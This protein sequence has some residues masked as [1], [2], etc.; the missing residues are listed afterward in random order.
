MLGRGWAYRVR[1]WPNGRQAISEF[2]LP[3]DIIGVHAALRMHHPAR[4][5]ALQPVMFQA[6]N[7]D[8]VPTLLA[9]RPVATYLLWL[10]CQSQRRAEERADQLIRL[11]AQE[12][13][14]A[15]LLGLY[16]RLSERNLVTA[17]HF[18][19][20]VTQQ[21]IADHLGLTVVHVNRMVRQLRETKI[22]I[23]IGRG[24]MIPDVARLRDFARESVTRNAAT[25]GRR[26]L[27]VIG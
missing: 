1:R 17:G 20:P 10:Q 22:A 6:I 25:G 8:A 3:G 23:V 4:I 26:L 24:V 11:D 16:E 7:P 9:R 2:Y 14:A 13:L 15:M 27:D 19:L 5:V 21:Q 12:R 18:Y